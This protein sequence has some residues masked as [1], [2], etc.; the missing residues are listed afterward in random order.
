MGLRVQPELQRFM[1]PPSSLTTRVMS[2]AAEHP[3]AVSRQAQ[4]SSLSRMRRSR[5]SARPRVSSSA[6]PSSQSIPQVADRTCRR[7]KLPDRR[8]YQPVRRSHYACAA[9]HVWSEACPATLGLTCPAGVD[10]P[11]HE[12]VC[13]QGICRLEPEGRLKTPEVFDRRTGVVRL[14]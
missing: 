11:A 1:C 10:Q 8:A 12:E 14:L 9:I 3:R 4:H 13:W 2:P 6:H 7:Y 5:H